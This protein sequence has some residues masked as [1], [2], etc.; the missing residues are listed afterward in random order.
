[1]FEDKT[2]ENLLTEALA[3]APAGIDTRQGSIYRDALTGPLLALAAIYTELE[4]L[5]SLTRVDTAV[6]EYLDDKGEE[7]GVDREPATLAKYRAVLDG[8]NPEEG[9]EFIADNMTFGLYYDDNGDPYFECETVGTAG[10]YVQEGTTAMPVN[11]L[12]NLYSA[13]FGELIAAAV[14]A[15]TD[16]DYRESI[17]QRLAF[18]AENGNKQHFKEWC[19]SVTGVGHAK[20]ISLWN[21]PNMVKGVLYGTDGSPASA[22]VVAAV[23][24]YVDPDEDG[25]GKGDGLGEGAAEIGCHFTAV[26]PTAYNVTVSAILV[27]ADG[28]DIAT[29]SSELQ[30]KIASYLRLMNMDSSGNTAPII[31]YNQI[32]SIIMDSDGVLD[33]L[34]LRLNGGTAN[35]QPSY[36]QAATLTAVNVTNG[37][38]ITTQPEDASATLNGTARFSVV[39]TGDS[40]TYRWQWAASGSDEWANSDLSGSSSANLNF[41]VTSADFNGRR[42]RCV[43]TSAGTNSVIS[44]EATLTVSSGS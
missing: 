11:D 31:R 1:M 34:N 2:Y 3:M 4:N 33:H 41:I 6:D 16:E 27:L 25:D 26:A 17:H 39:A 15:Q 7:Y 32:S 30:T 24:A 44:G 19:E 9:E 40:L 35:L 42:Y 13:E 21:G 10:N 28:F 36:D 5:V 43:V 22:S 8:D 20:I 14:D 23:Q 38:F 12:E 29:V 18:P 37:P